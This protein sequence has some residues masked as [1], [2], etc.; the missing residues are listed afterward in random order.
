MDTNNI[1]VL[2]KISSLVYSLTHTKEEIEMVA[3]EVD[4]CNL[5]VALNGLSQESSNFATELCMQF[6]NSGLYFPKLSLEELQGSNTMAENETVEG[7]GDELSYICRR[8][9]NFLMSAYN[10]I[11]NENFLFPGLRD[12]MT[13]QLNALKSAFLKIS[14]LNNARFT[15]LSSPF[16]L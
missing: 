16:S 4:D 11:L 15:G 13:Y 9:E 8:N 1:N 14:L 5:R 10:L 12:I 7:P 6:K 2:A 3:D